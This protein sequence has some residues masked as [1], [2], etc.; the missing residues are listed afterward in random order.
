MRRT[1][2]ERSSLQSTSGLAQGSSRAPIALSDARWPINWTAHARGP[3]ALP[4]SRAT[5][6]GGRAVVIL[7]A[8]S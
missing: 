2:S 8:L 6:V 1:D 5:Q 3:S 7:S 4:R